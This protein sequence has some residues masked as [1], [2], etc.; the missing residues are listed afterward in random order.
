MQAASRWMCSSMHQCG[1]MSSRAFSAA[2]MALR[3]G[4]MPPI[5]GASTWEMSQ[6]PLSTSQI[7]S[8]GEVSISPVATGVANPR[9]HRVTLEIER[10]E[11]LLDE[12]EADVVG[13][14]ADL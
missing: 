13:N 7:A 6:A 4:V 3:N 8:C 10:V 2:A 9:A 11:R 14:P 1:A 12:G 5:R